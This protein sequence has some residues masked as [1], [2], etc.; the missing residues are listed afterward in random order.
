MNQSWQRCTASAA[1]SRPKRFKNAK[2]T[3]KVVVSTACV[4]TTGNWQ[5]SKTVRWSVFCLGK[6]GIFQ[7]D[8]I[9]FW[10]IAN[11]EVSETPELLYEIVLKP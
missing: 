2:N 5:K 11:S 6:A 9:V 7:A 4:S 10:D 8:K 1:V 3:L